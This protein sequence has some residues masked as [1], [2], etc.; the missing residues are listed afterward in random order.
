M[1]P[2]PKR[3]KSNVGKWNRW[4]WKHKL[5]SYIPFLKKNVPIYGDSTTY[6]VAAEFLSD[7]SE[8]EDWGCGL[9]G[10]RRFCKTKYVG[11]D[12]SWT[13][14]CDRVVDLATYRSSTDG[15]LLRHVLEHNYEWR[16]ILQNAV[17]SFRR[18][19][20]VVIFTP[21]SDR[22]H[23]IHWWPELQ[24]PDISFDREELLGYFAGLSVRS[25]EGLKTRSQYNVEHI[26]FLEK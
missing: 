20:C 6:Q 22:T 19:M 25:Q 13:A 10:F 26:F 1:L 23:D 4:Y 8:V 7:V 18:K 15:I 17:A 24:V 9:G 3:D 12:G 21:F 14:S 5:R 16:T 2:P 11:V